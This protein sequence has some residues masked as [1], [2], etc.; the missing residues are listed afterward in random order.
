MWLLPRGPLGVY[1]IAAVDPPA[2][3]RRGINPDPQDFADPFRFHQAL[4]RLMSIA[5]YDSMEQWELMH[6]PAATTVSEEARQTSLTGLDRGPARIDWGRVPMAQREAYAMSL[7]VE[8]YGFSR[9]AA[10]GIVGNLRAEGRLVPNM[11][12]SGTDRNPML[13]QAADGRRRQLSAQE[14][15]VGRPL[16]GVGIAQWTAG[17]NRR[18]HREDWSRRTRLW[19]YWPGGPPMSSMRHAVENLFSM[20]AQIDYLVQE[21]GQP[22]FARLSQ[23]LARRG[24]TVEEASD[25]FLRRFERPR[26]PNFAERRQ[27]AREALAAFDQALHPA[28]P[29]PHPAPQRRDPAPGHPG[30]QQQP[31]RRRPRP[32]QIP[33]LG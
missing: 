14:A 3:Q 32:V 21:L 17:V 27:Y 19:D 2:F 8:G 6:H 26:V 29:A 23:T 18:T 7:L 11:V 9:E 13:A 15:I 24:L 28:A 1:P 25:E 20:R 5:L 4:A 12:E 31:I 33:P 10:A 30:G 22:E 16:Q